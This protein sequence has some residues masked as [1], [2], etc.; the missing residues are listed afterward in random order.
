MKLDTVIVR[1]LTFELDFDFDFDLLK[2]CL[3][4]LS[5]FEIRFIQ[6]G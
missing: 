4:Y 5:I 6:K 1:I 3:S 2:K